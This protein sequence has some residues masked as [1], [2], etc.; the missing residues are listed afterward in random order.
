MLGL[1]NLQVQKGA[2]KKSQRRGRGNASR[3][4]NYSG[5]GM[6]GQKSRSGGKSGLKKLGMR[7]V[8]LQLPKLRGFNRNSKRPAVVNVSDIEKNFK[9]GSNITQKDLLKKGLVKS[10]S[11]GV[12]ILGTGT[13]TKKFTVSAHSFSVTAK[14]LIER[15]GGSVVILKKDRKKTVSKKPKKE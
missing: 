4:G 14:E 7:N 11:S 10:T 12:K 2:K 5:R 15:A 9:T 1:N 3:R 6:K 8:I 13:I